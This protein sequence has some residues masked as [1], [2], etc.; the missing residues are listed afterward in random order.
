MKRRG[1]T[2]KLITFLTLRGIGA[3]LNQ[4]KTKF[5]SGSEHVRFSVRGFSAKRMAYLLNGVQL[6][7]LVLV[8][9]D[10]YY[11]AGGGIGI[12]SLTLMLA[13]LVLGFFCP[14]NDKG[15][16]FPF[17]LGFAILIMTSLLTPL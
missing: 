16:F 15:R 4:F 8:N 9:L 3:I 5:V 1:R 14:R 2:I 7:L 6:W 13:N 11:D 10:A 17:A 12:I